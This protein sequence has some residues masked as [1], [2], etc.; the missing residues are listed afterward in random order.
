MIFPKACHLGTCC[1]LETEVKTSCPPHRHGTTHQAEGAQGAPQGS[2][3]TEYATAHRAT[4]LETAARG[5]SPVT[6]E[7]AALTVLCEV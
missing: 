1:G 6:A 4:V 7:A 3:V 2:T 5:Q